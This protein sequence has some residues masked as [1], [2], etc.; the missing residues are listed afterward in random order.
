LPNPKDL[1]NVANKPKPLNL[2]LYALFAIGIVGKSFFLVTTF[3][4]LIRFFK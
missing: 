1:A 3:L 2:A 4:K